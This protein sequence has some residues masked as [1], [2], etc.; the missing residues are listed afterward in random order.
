MQIN[1]TLIQDFE[2]GLNP[3]YPEKSTIPATIVG[4]GEISSIFKI[5]PYHDWVFKR[6]P[7]FNSTEQAIQYIVK[8]K[9]YTAYL[10]QAGLSL[11]LDDTFVISSKKVVLYVAQ[12]ALNKADLCQNK[13]HALPAKEVIRMLE[14]IFL[15]IKKLA[16][17]NKNSKSVLL[18][19]D[20]QVS[21]WALVENDLYYFDT[22]TPLF[23]INGVEQMNAELLLNSTPKALRWIISLFFLKEV[24]NRYYDLRLIY[25]DLIA[26]L[27]KE[28]TPEYIV[29]A[30]NLANDLLPKSIKK[31]TKVEVAKYYK[32]DKL[33]WRL[34]LSF[35]RIDRWFSKNILRKQYEFILPGTIKR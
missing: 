15:A 7:L 24:M 2:R 19:I 6:L 33:I 20:G 13:L 5:N 29:P 17:F 22:S 23:K 34:F 1:P 21:N 16:D 12:K 18:S 14:T 30:I 35:R 27:Y 28:Q 10:K 26:N 25:I 9:L 4:F 32:K 31:I 3:Q 8:Y 11:P